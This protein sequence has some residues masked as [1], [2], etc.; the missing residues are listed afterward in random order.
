MKPIDCRHCPLRRLP[1]YLD[2]SPAELSF[3]QGFKVGEETVPAGKIVLSQGETA[4]NLYTV[5]EGFATRSVLLEDGRRQVLNFVFPGDLLGLQA[6][7]MGEMQHS[8]EA[9]TTLRLCVFRRSRLWELFRESPDRAFD[10]TWIG[11]VEEHFLGETIATLGQRS[12]LQ[13]TAWSL[14][15]MWTRLTAL[16]MRMGSHV[17]LP[18]RQSELADALGMSVV[19]TNRMITELR[20]RNIASWSHKRLTVHDE[21]KLRQIAGLANEG[22]VQR[23]LM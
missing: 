22:E 23:P 4:A 7:L 18:Y 14:A 13:R 19:H 1:V 12:A 17:P 2:F 16:G 9:T 21:T 10:L 8:V 5:L 11:A 15:R 3:M 20:T 6:A